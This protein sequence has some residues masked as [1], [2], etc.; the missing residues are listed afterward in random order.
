MSLNT[1]VSYFEAPSGI[2]KSCTFANFDYKETKCYNCNEALVSFNADAANWLCTSNHSLFC[3]FCLKFI[4]RENVCHINY[5]YSI[6][7]SDTC[8]FRWHKYTNEQKLSC[9]SKCKN[10][11]FVLNDAASDSSKKLSWRLN[12]PKA[13]HHDFFVQIQKQFTATVSFKNEGFV[14]VEVNTDDALQKIESL[15]RDGYNDLN[16]T[17]FSLT[18]LVL[19]Y[20][21]KQQ[22]KRV[23]Q[24]HLQMEDSLAIDGKCIFILGSGSIQSERFNLSQ[25]SHEY[26]ANQVVKNE[27]MSKFANSVAQ[28]VDNIPVYYASVSNTV[29][30]N[31]DSMNIL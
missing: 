9:F 22:Y 30:S 17:P 5:C 3:S 10:L 24:T 20:E 8:R 4:S 14:T 19:P 27:I 29:Q 16:I 31:Y 26:T 18:A 1:I 2:C 28:V 15:S 25:M 23:K 6:C 12:S 21:M 11:N 7:N 13:V